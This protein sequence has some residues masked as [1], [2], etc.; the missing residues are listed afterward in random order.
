MIFVCCLGIIGLIHY[1]TVRKA[2]EVA[3]RKIIGATFIQVAGIL[4][5]NF[6]EWVIIANLIAWPIAYFLMDGWLQ[7]FTYKTNM[8]W[9]IFLLSGC[10]AMVIALFTAGYHTIR[11]ARVNPVEVLRSE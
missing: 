7:S 10:I 1:T 4:L 11:A 8:A 2:K 5:R 3:V 9:W 6:A